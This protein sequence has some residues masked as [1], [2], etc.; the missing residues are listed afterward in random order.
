MPTTFQWWVLGQG[1]LSKQLKPSWPGLRSWKDKTATIHFLQAHTASR[2]RRV[3]L[4][5]SSFLASSLLLSLYPFSPKARPSSKLLPEILRFIKCKYDSVTLLKKK[6][7]ALIP[8]ALW[9]LRLVHRNQ[10]PSSFADIASLLLSLYT[11]IFFSDHSEIF[12]IFQKIPQHDKL[13]HISKLLFMP[14]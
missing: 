11:H 9:Q 4:L 12:R 1:E 14:F 13:L 6:K 8:I 10:T 5:I 3:H 2:F 7:N